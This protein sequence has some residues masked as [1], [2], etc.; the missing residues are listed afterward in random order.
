MDQKSKDD[1]IKRLKEK[2][3]T[4]PCPRCGSSS[5][6]LLDG[7]FNETIQS[8]LPGIVLGGPTVPSVATACSRC[9]FL[10]QHALSALGLL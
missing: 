7:Y 1:V 2:G 3:V 6:S 5:F 4:L 10:S 9:G 8:M